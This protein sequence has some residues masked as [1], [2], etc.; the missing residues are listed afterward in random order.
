VGDNLSA[1]DSVMESLFFGSGFILGMAIFM[2]LIVSLALVNKYLGALTFPLLVYLEV[3]YYDRIVASPNTMRYAFGM[4]ICLIL[5][6]FI[7]LN[8]ALRKGK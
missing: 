7:A 8:V 5:L 2:I 6:V 4:L 3:E 1:I